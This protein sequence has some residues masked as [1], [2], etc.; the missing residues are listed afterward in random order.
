MKNFQFVIA[1]EAKQSNGIASPAK[2]IGRVRND[3]SWIPAFTGMTLVLAG[4]FLK[5]LPF[6]KGRPDYGVDI[7]WHGHSCF[8]IKDS[9]NRTIVIDPFDETVGYGRLR[10]KAD[11][12]LVTHNHFDHNHVQA[13]KA[14]IKNIDLVDSTGTT[15]VAA[16]LDVNGVNAPHD[17]EA[18]DLYGLT[19]IYSFDMGGLRL[20]HLGDVGTPDLSPAVMG[21]IGRPDILF[22]PVGGF[23]TLDAKEAK[24][25]VDKIKP[26]AVIPMHYGDIRF[27]KLAPV[28]DFTQLFPEK[29]VV[30]LHDSHVRIRR[31]DLKS[32]PVVYTFIPTRND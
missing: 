3:K 5:P 28:T 15:S 29:D 14:R 1:S 9:V 24:E 26:G 20:V 21:F 18:G 7:T 4:C 23:T 13:V 11:A 25:L 2:R 27:Y 6:Q 32:E 10:L 19:R 30:D 17:D 8:T 22:I 31:A 12:V 16:G